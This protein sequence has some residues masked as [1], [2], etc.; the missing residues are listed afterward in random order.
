MFASLSQWNLGY[1]KYSVITGFCQMWDLSNRLLRV[2]RIS[3][4]LNL[5]SEMIHHYESQFFLCLGGAGWLEWAGSGCFASPGYKDRA[6]WIFS[7]LR[8]VRLWLD[9]F[10]WGQTLL[11]TGISG[12]VQ[13][14]SFSPSPCWKY[15]GI[16]LWYLL[17]ESGWLKLL[18][19]NLTVLW[20]PPYDLDLS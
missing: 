18:E 20:G 7:F 3:Y 5:G 1:T 13:N 15:E 19:V 8:S 14:S 4:I 17:G 12:V 2:T 16:F 10:C 6:R 9:S 11:R